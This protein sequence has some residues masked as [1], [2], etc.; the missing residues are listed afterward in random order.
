MDNSNKKKADQLGM[1]QG[2]A[3]GRLRKSIILNLLKELKKNYCF[4][5]GAEIENERQLS[6]EHKIPWLDSEDPNKLFFDLGNIAFSHL[7]CNVGA[8]RQ[9]IQKN[10]RGKLEYRGVRIDNRRP[11]TPYQAVI[12][13]GSK[14]LKSKNYTLIIDAAK[15]YDEMSTELFGENA[16]TNK[17]LG[18]Y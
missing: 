8:A 4:Q 2:T 9:S 12:W 10:K 15:K 3:A 11:D 17:K 13:N 5:C 7:T 18:L 1:P 6:I 14:Y 16:L